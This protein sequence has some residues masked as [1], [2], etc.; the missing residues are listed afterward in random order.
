MAHAPAATQVEGI[1]NACRNC[2][3]QASTKDAFDTYAAFLAGRVAEGKLTQAD[4][5]E[6]L[7]AIRKLA[8]ALGVELTAQAEVGHYAREVA[9]GLVVFVLAEA[10]EFGTI[11]V[12]HNDGTTGWGGR[13]FYAPM[14]ED[15]EMSAAITYA[16][17]PGSSWT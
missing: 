11:E 15:E 2:H 13:E 14:T 17:R 1:G 9:T 6:R 12:R 16:W 10:P 8:Q 3:R 7:T 5:D 4:I